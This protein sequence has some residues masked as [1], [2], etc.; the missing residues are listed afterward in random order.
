LTDERGSL[1][2]GD[3]WHPDYRPQAYPDQWPLDLSEEEAESEADAV[4][5]EAPFQLSPL[6][7]IDASTETLLLPEPSSAS[8]PDPEAV[9]EWEVTTSEII[10]LEP[11]LDLETSLSLPTEPMWAVPEAIPEIT[12][13]I[14]AEPQLANGLGEYETSSREILEVG[15]ADASLVGADED[16]E[17]VEASD[18][19]EETASSSLPEPAAQVVTAPAE[20]ESDDLR[21]DRVDEWMTE[22][23]PEIV[24]PEAPLAFPTVDSKDELV[25]AVVIEAG[26]SPELDDSAEELTVGWP[27][28]DPEPRGQAEEAAK[29]EELTAPADDGWP[30]WQPEAREQAA[31]MSPEAVDNSMAEEAADDGWPKWDPGWRDREPLEPAVSEVRAGETTASSRFDMGTPPG[32]LESSNPWKPDPAMMSSREYALAEQ[33]A[34]DLEPASFSLDRFE[35]HHFLQGATQEHVGL[36]K[37]METAGAGEDKPSP[38]MAAP[39][40]GVE[41]GVVG[42]DDVGDAEESFEIGEGGGGLLPASSELGTRLFSGVL[43]ISAFVLA[44]AL[45]RAWLWGLVGLIALVAM[46][47]FFAVLRHLGHRPVAIFGMLG[48]AGALIGSSTELGVVAVAGAVALATVGVFAF[49]AAQVHPPHRPWPNAALTVLGMA[50]VA[51]GL[52]FAMPIIRADNRVRL[53]VAIVGLTMAMDTG[54]YFAGRRWG[55][56]P[57]ASTLSPKKTVEGLVGGIGLTAAVAVGLGLWLDPPFSIGTALALAAGVAIFA[58]LGDLA[59]SMLKRQ[60]EIKDMGW[61]LPG[62][63]GLLDRIDS[64]LFVVPAAYTVLRWTGIL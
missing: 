8:R 56:R 63:G 16:Y 39:M 30:K 11:A 13:S 37:A 2:P 62:H 4:E 41:S 47:E 48:G 26:I 9:A 50:W 3:P 18:F 57:L 21:L 42:L 45:G 12:K 28:W 64:F 46:G 17:V 27:K 49:Y 33:L 35:D 55:H 22:E 15:V 10:R 60:L 40:P 23:H 59:E 7:P 51:G 53:L 34:A 44:L 36:A 19:S 5:A 25:E 1:H 24:D 14:Q 58:V 20:T 32:W 52:A 61:L 54:A 6:E 31:E 38:A 29:E 43:L